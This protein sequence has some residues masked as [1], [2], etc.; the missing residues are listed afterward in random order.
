MSRAD[1][2]H[3]GTEPDNRTDENRNRSR[4]PVY[5]LESPGERL[6]CMYLDRVPAAYAS[7]LERDLRLSRDVI[8]VALDSLLERDFV[9]QRGGLYMLS[10]E[11]V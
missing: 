9:R 4:S 8:A 5:D 1:R 10:F 3:M 11:Q 2:P 6:V 7:D